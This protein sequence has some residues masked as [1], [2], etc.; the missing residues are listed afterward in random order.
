MVS[1]QAQLKYLNRR[2]DEMSC[3]EDLLNQKNFTEA[4]LLCHKVK[5]SA[6]TFKFGKLGEIASHLELACE[7]NPEIA[8]E[9]F[10]SYRRTV[11]QLRDSMTSETETFAH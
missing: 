2:I 3:L 7:S 4:S 1:R 8:T 5:G 6:S 9:L 10:Q 11:D